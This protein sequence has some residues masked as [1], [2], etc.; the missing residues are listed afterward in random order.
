MI[1]FCSSRVAVSYTRHL[2]AWLD[3][4]QHLTVTGAVSIIVRR[5]ICRKCPE[6]LATRLAPGIRKY[7]RHTAKALGLHNITTRYKHCIGKPLQYNYSSWLISDLFGLVHFSICA[8][9]PCAG[10]MLIFSV[11]FQFY[12]RIPFGW[13]QLFNPNGRAQRS[14]S[15]RVTRQRPWRQRAQPRAG[16]ACRV[17]HRTEAKRG[18]AKACRVSDAADSSSVWFELINAY[19]RLDCKGKRDFLVRCWRPTDMDL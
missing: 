16:S 4:L 19:P 12:R 7:L 17:L 14:D 2:G 9:H 11:S 18:K 5:L 6:T 3:Q 1:P 10:A 8:C 13:I 15:L